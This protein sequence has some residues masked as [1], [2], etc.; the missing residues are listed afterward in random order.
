LVRDP[1]S[2]AARGTVQASPHARHAWGSV[3]RPILVVAL[4]L[5]VV[6]V[7]TRPLA[8]RITRP[9]E[10]LTEAA[11]RLGGGDLGARAPVAE[12]ASG[13]HR[14]RTGRPVEE[15]SELTRTFNEM[16]DRV[17]RMVRGEKELLAN[18]SHELRSPLARI[19]MALE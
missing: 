7:A 3:F 6:A 15:I 13:R 4:V 10:R 1:I 9:L 12:P 16:V 18:V 11:R 17:E 5:V 19:R 14:R 8:R 2:G